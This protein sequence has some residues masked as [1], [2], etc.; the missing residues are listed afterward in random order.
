MP[1]ILISGYDSGEATAR[2][3]KAGAVAFL[4]EATRRRCA[5]ACYRACHRTQPRHAWSRRG[6]VN[7][8]WQSDGVDVA[9]RARNAV[10]RG[11]V[12]DS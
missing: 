10:G 4:H 2:A 9:P 12:N 3:M 5:F 6:G 11:G 1:V 8:P 7:S